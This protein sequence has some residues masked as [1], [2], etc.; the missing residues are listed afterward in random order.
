MQT[1]AAPRQ[2]FYIINQLIVTSLEEWHAAVVQAE[3]KA[4]LQAL[5]TGGGSVLNC[6]TLL[7]GWHGASRPPPTVKLAI[8]RRDKAHRIEAQ[9]GLKPLVRSCSPWH[10]CHITAVF[11]G[12][13]SAMRLQS[14]QALLRQIVALA[15]AYKDTADRP[16]AQADICAILFQYG[17]HKHC[18]E[19]CCCIIS[20]ACLRTGSN[21]FQHASSL[22]QTHTIDK[23]CRFCV[24]LKSNKP[25]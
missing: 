18:S 11:L 13:T 4:H 2:I 15:H 21:Q 8:S 6:C 3:L 17:Q 19:G 16:V 14:V 5:L 25:Y 9:G 24:R 23:Y 12:G 7:L 20:S 22:Y 1:L 10:G